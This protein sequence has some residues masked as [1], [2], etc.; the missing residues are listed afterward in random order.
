MKGEMWPIEN[1]TAARRIKW[2]SAQNTIS[3]AYMKQLRERNETKKVYPCDPYVEVYQFRDNLYGLFTQNCDGAGDVWM[4]LI[5]GPEKCMLIDTAFGLGDTKALVDQLSGGREII[6]VNTHGHVDH[7]YGNCRFE[8]VY[9]SEYEVP[10]LEKQNAHM[11]DYLFDADGRNIWLDFDKKDL[12]V[13]K[14]YEI[15]GVPDGYSWDLGGGYEVELVWLGGHSAGMAAYLDKHN[16]ILFTGDDLC[17][18]VSGVA[19]GPREGDAYPEY[20]NLTTFRN[21]LAELVERIG[22]YDYLFPSHFM[23]NIENIVLK[24][25]LEACDEIL[26]D[27]DHPD[28]IRTDVSG[29]GEIRTRKFKYIRGFSLLA[30]TDKGLY[31]EGKKNG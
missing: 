9:C 16:R 11:F 20:K 31:P 24:N 17:S 26:R 3:W 22:E 2:G 19:A 28:L 12:P 15:A 18:D 29:H 5:I 30:Y 1:A 14:P 25:E 4:F 8:K 10:L 13:F 6:V 27:P 7:S 21:N 23:V